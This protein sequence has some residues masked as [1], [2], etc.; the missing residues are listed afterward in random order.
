LGSS[1]SSTSTA[2]PSSTFTDFYDFLDQYKA[3]TPDD[4]PTIIND[5]LSWQNSSG[6]GFPAIVNATHVVFIY[7]DPT[8]TISTCQVS[9]DAF[10]VKPHP[11]FADWDMIQ[12]E[13]GVSFFYHAFTLHPATRTGYQ[14]CVDG[15]WINDPRNA[16]QCK[17]GYVVEGGY[18]SELAMPLF[19]REFYHIYRPEVSHG[20]VTPLTNY[21]TTPYVRIYLPPNFNRSSVYPVVYFPDGQYYIDIMDTPIILDNLMAD[22]LIIPLIAVF[23]DYV[24]DRGFYYSDKTTYFNDLDPL[25][26]HID[27]HYPTIA[28]RAGRLHVGLSL[29]GYISAIVGL[30]RS[31]TFRNIAIQ[32]MAFWSEDIPTTYSDV[33]SSLD[34]N[35]WIC[36]GTYELWGDDYNASDDT[37]VVAQFFLD[38]TWD[39]SLHFYPEGHI[40]PFWAHTL[41]ELLIHFYP[42]FIPSTTSQTTTSTST[43]TATEM[44]SPTT[45]IHTSEDAVYPGLIFL[46]GTIPVIIIIRKKRK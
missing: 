15:S 33:D 40:Y 7:Y 38:K 26:A 27:E 10:S 8:E 5:Y 29:S 22:N 24:G 2:L 17:V 6:G 44:T 23:S 36:C 43:S 11:Y 20:T 25:V 41:D 16:Y 18:V 32:S 31:E 39:V 34:L 3:A 46:L 13:S 35:I 19:E 45:T 30:E 14:F 28:S 1:F 42:S 21:S 9:L 4:K 12:L 37:K